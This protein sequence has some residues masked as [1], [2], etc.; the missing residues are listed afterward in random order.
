MP[1]EGPAGIWDVPSSKEMAVLSSVKW[2]G[3]GRL[4]YHGWW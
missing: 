2:E 3:S 1:G 4:S